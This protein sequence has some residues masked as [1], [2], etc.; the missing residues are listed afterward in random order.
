MIKIKYLLLA[1]LLAWVGFMTVDFLEEFFY[2]D[3][4]LE[5]CFCFPIIIGIVYFMKRKS[6]RKERYKELPVWKK[7]VQFIIVVLEWCFITASITT[8]IT[9]LVFNETWIIP[10]GRGF[11]NGVEYPV[12]GFFLWSIPTL[13]VLMGELIIWVYNK[14]KASYLKK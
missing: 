4:Q 14:C 12:Y 1:Q 9:F 3:L 11:L 5:A 8:I 10:Q 6:I 13:F 2:I 7:L